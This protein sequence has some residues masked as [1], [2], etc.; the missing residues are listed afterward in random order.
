[1][2]RLLGNI[3]NASHHK[4]VLNFHRAHGSPVHIKPP[5]S[6]LYTSEHDR[7]SRLDDETVATFDNI[8]NNLSAIK[9]A[10]KHHMKQLMKHE[11]Q[12]KGAHLDFHEDAD[13]MSHCTLQTANDGV[14]TISSV[15]LASLGLQSATQRSWKP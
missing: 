8:V 11:Q 13:N 12:Q 10:R 15:G 4:K 1:L 9:Q 5:N 14:S 6:R 2:D 3:D 7:K